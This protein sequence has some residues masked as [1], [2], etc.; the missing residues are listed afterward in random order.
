LYNHLPRT[1]GVD[2]AVEQQGIFRYACDGVLLAVSVEDPFG[3]F[4]RQ[5]ILDYLQSCYDGR[6]G[7]L[8]G[9]RKKG[10]AGRGLF[11]IMET[12]DLV[13]INVKA[14]IKTEVIA[15]FNID[16][17]KQRGKAPTSFHYF[18]S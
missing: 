12:A 5:T 6:A 16:S 4:S 11:H 3:V 9:E 14:R 7:T 13:A 10:G 1:E 18:Y 2:L 8:Q 15:I 17:N